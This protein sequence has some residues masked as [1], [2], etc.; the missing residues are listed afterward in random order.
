MS[1]PEIL[2]PNCGEY[3]VLLYGNSRGTKTVIDDFAHQTYD[4]K[5]GEFVFTAECVECDFS[6]TRRLE[7]E[8]LSGDF[9]IF[10][11]GSSAETIDE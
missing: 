3:R 9:G 6:Q 11:Q 5:T 4:P 10:L 1:E 7:T 2:C 8:E